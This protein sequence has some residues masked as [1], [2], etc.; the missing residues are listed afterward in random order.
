MAPDAWSMA[1][2]N[3]NG[4]D[5]FG[6]NSNRDGRRDLPLHGSIAALIQTHDDSARGNKVTCG[7]QPLPPQPAAYL[8]TWRSK[9]R[10]VCSMLR[11]LSET[12]SSS[13]PALPAARLGAAMPPYLRSG[14]PARRP[15]PPATE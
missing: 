11:A 1:R 9:C 5:S 2:D 15:S 3:A 4:A 6:N 12:D 14:R 7:P 13:E 8:K 10:G